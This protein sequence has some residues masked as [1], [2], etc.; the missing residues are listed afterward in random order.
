MLGMLISIFM[1]LWFLFLVIV[2]LV[3]GFKLLKWLIT[4]NHSK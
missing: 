2:S 4:G 1:M 3:L